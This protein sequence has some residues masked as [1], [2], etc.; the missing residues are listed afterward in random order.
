MAFL[1][2]NNNVLNMTIVT[3]TKTDFLKK[4]L[5]F[6]RMKSL[7]QYSLRIGIQCSEQHKHFE[8]SL[9]ISIIFSSSIELRA[10]LLFL[11]HFKNA[12]NKK[13]LRYY[14]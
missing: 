4:D 9:K 8:S 7:L 5:I 3:K 1:P 14:L 6:D 11:N 2:I 13:R 12:D 10:A